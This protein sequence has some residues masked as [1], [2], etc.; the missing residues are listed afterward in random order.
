M[1]RREFIEK[2][3]ARARER[4]GDAAG[5]ACEVCYSQG[6][7]FEVTVRDGEILKYSVS[8]G[9]GLGF[10]AL[11]NGRMGYAS[12]QILDEDAID[13]L[14]DGALENAA[15]VE[16]EDRQF[17]FAGSDSYPELKLFESELE[18][19]DAAQKIEMARK[20]EK[21]TLAQDKRIDRDEYTVFSSS[22]ESGIVNTLGLD[23]S[24][25]SNLLGGY[26]SAIARQGDRVNTGF[27]LFFATRPE[28]ID[29]EGVA[30]QAA[31][32]A[33]DGL[34]AVQ[35]ASGVYRV[36]LRNDVAAT[37][38]AT[39]S[40]VFSADNAQRGLSR[41]KGREG[42]DIAAACVTLLDDPHRAG[43]AASTPFD[44]EGVATRPKA[45]IEGGRLNTL[46]HNLKTAHKQGVE[47][48]ANASRPGYAAPVGV[49]PTNFY[50]KPTADSLE[51]MLK[52]LGDGLLIT[53]L[54]GMHAGA[55]PITGD[56]S[57]AAKGF[58]VRGGE[59]AEAVAQITIAGNFYE[60]LKAVEAVGGDL[61]FLAPGASCFGSPS[62]LI[63][64]LSVAGE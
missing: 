39:F 1:E 7:S 37:L 10:R 4:A 26:A 49:A 8:D 30:A 32:E 36:L 14:V 43:S 58:R 41:L 60:L 17:L 38:L 16:G 20:L 56:F 40:G 18:Q 61:D 27:K 59:R 22:D 42:E 55:N 2:L 48:T 9:G 3:F 31:R 29:L 51:D 44:G 13:M 28:D 54:Q 33:L 25:R 11:V 53:D 57:L 52:K 50:F 19:I 46:L 34:D 45:V 6:S 63:S 47:T 5:F 12:T 15:L 23:V 21:L 62:L 24:A 35:A 64:Q